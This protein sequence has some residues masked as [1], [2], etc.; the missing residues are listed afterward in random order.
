MPSRPKFTLEEEEVKADQTTEE[1]VQVEGRKEEEEE[2][3]QVEVEGAATKI[4]IKSKATANKVDKIKHIDK[5]MINPK[6]N[7]ITVGS[8]G[9]MPMNVGRT[10]VTW[11]IDPVL[12]LLNKL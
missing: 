8:M 6:S 3:L 10:R 9:I 5:G 11:V 1:K 12:I 7:V 2:A 4:R